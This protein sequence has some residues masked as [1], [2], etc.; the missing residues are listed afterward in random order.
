MKWK[1]EGQGGQ[2]GDVKSKLSKEFK[3][4]LELPNELNHIKL[5]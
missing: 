2:E 4:A 5:S 3:V 1:L